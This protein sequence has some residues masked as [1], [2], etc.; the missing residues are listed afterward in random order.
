MT[1]VATARF[2]RVEIGYTLVELI[3]VIAIVALLAAVAAPRFADTDVFEQ[4]STAN[5]LA[6]AL[7]YGQ[8]IAVASG[9]R[10]QVELDAAGYRLLQQAISANHCGAGGFSNPVLW[11]EGVAVDEATTG[12]PATSFF[13]NT[14]GSTSLA[15]TL[16]LTVGTH[17]VSVSPGG[18]VSSS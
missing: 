12:L 17:S 1:T 7:R 16:S 3:T 15:S 10:V 4:R 9:C 5:E 13:W 11:P 6:A 2:V 18:L 14:D 8:R